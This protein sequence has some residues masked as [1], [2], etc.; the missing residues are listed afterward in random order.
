MISLFWKIFGATVIAF[1]ILIAFN[2]TME[3]CFKYAPPIG[4]FVGVFMKLRE[5][6]KK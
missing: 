3:Q 4:L 1:L 6:I 5:T 2:A